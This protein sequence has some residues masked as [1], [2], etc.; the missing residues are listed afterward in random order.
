[1][2]WEKPNATDLCKNQKT[3]KYFHQNEWAKKEGKFPF[4]VKIN[5]ASNDE[6]CIQGGPGGQY[7]LV[8]VNL[9]M[10]GSGKMLRIR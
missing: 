10:E 4:K 9:F 7:R 6:Y 5:P 1:M 2:F 8:D 3:S